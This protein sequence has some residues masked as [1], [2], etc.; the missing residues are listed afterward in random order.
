MG[1]VVSKQGAVVVTGA[2]VCRN[3]H[4]CRK[5]PGWVVEWVWLCRNGVWL[6]KRALFCVEMGVVG[7]SNGRSCRN[8]RRWVFQTGVV[9]KTGRLGRRISAGGSVGLAFERAV[10]R[11]AAG[12]SVG[13]GMGWWLSNR[14]GRRRWASFGGGHFFKRW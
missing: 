10:V 6:S 5:R 9:V 1:A 7:L 3:G 13:G 2:V 4:G 8:R 12:G 14:R 11:T